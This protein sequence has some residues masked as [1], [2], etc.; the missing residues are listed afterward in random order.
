MTKIWISWIDSLSNKGHII[1]NTAHY[2]TKNLDSGQTHKIRRT[3]WK[4]SAPFPD[5]RSIALILTIAPTNPDVFSV[6]KNPRFPPLTAHPTCIIEW[7]AQFLCPRLKLLTGTSDP[8]LSDV[9]G[10][11][12]EG[13]YSNSRNACQEP[14]WASRAEISNNFLRGTLSWGQRHL[15]IAQAASMTACYCNV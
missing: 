9:E 8:R 14:D 12:W 13:N 15:R 10:V 4:K 6:C 3:D 7:H 11:A 2:Y 1:I 5:R